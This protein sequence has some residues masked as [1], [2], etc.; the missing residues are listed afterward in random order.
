MFSESQTAS[1]SV[2]PSVEPVAS[3]P[4]SRP[5]KRTVQKKAVCIDDDLPEETASG[6]FDEAALAALEAETK[7]RGKPAES[8][9]VL[10][11]KKGDAI[12]HAREHKSKVLMDGGE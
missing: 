9:P 12:P 3:I 2:T 5:E 7:N 1:E 11:Q 4:P 6:G 8:A 10:Q